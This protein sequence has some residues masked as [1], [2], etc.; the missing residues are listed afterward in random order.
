MLKD[1]LVG[2]ALLSKAQL[3]L[4]EPSCSELLLVTLRTSYYDLRA[5]S[6]WS[7]ELW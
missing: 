1:A 5:V 2:L 4:L 3:D 7:Q 6:N